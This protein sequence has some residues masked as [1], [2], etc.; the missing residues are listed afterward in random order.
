MFVIKKKNHFHSITIKF[1]LIF[2]ILLKKAITSY[3]D[4]PMTI[5]TIQTSSESVF[6]IRGND[7]GRSA[8][9]YILVPINKLAEFKSLRKGDNI[10]VTE[11]G[12][13]IKYRNKRGEIKEMSGWEAEPPEMFVYGY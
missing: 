13:I 12:R 8:W 4:R 10:N 2:I 3:A 11:Y 1:I 7:R 9:H 5:I 6:T